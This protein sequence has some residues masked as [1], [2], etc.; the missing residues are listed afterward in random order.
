MVQPKK[1]F[2]KQTKKINYL[3]KF[4]NTKEWKI[5]IAPKIFEYKI[6]GYIINNKY[7]NN[8]GRLKEISK[9]NLEVSLSELINDYSSY[10]KIIKLQPYT[11]NKMFI[12]TTF[13]GFRL[14]YDFI[15]S[16]VLKPTKLVE[17][18]IKI[19]TLKKKV[20]EIFVLYTI[21]KNLH[22]NSIT[23]GKR[24]RIRKINR[25]SILCIKKML[26]NKPI[27]F[28]YKICCSDVIGNSI[29][30]RSKRKNT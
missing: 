23:Y 27:D 26:E 28:I 21:T 14:S 30:R 1:K 9:R 24:S 10:Y 3:E 6:I 15:F 29:K 22:S 13:N 11:M 20:V 16:M 5:V 7:T 4:K 25:E 12:R 17:F 8:S 2:S 19:N 18:S